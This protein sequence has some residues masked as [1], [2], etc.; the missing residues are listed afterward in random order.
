[1]NQFLWWLELF[2][3]P[4]GKDLTYPPNSCGWRFG[5]VWP[6]ILTQIRRRPDCMKSRDLNKTHKVSR[7]LGS[8][9]SWFKLKQ[10]KTALVLLISLKSCKWLYSSH[11]S[12]IFF[13]FSSYE[14]L[15]VWRKWKD[16][17]SF[18]CVNKTG[19]IFQGPGLCQGLLVLF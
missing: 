16:I 19:H 5:R 18:E 3:L 4:K 15:N 17:V 12:R 2:N 1:M 10:N 13:F 6:I 7:V 9:M 11:C 14:T 8:L